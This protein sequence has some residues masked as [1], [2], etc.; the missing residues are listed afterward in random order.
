[1]RVVGLLEDQDSG[2]LQLALR[3]LARAVLLR[4]LH[5]D[6]LRVLLIRILHRDL[7]G[8]F[9]LGVLLRN[10]HGNLFRIFLFSVLLLGVWLLGVLLLGVLLLGILLFRVLL[11]CGGVNLFLDLGEGHLHLLT[12]FERAQ[13]GL[14]AGDVRVGALQ[15]L[16]LLL[17]VL[18]GIAHV[19]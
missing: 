14:V 8:V 16:D 1:D 9:L 17:G 10:L 6:F 3:G 4:D 12:G 5:G 7:L 11:L 18:L 15:F 19:V 2:C 13:V